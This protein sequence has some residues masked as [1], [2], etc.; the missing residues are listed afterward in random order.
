MQPSASDVATVVTTSADDDQKKKCPTSVCYIGVPVCYIGV[1]LLLLKLT[2]LGDGPE[3]V[4]GLTALG[5]P[6]PRT[7]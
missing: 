7:A 6:A 3:H 2:D 1:L 4:V 5:P